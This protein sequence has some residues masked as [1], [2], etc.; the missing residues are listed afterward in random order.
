MTIKA[1]Q[2][3]EL[4]EATG[5]GLM[6]CKKALVENNGDLDKSIRWLRER[7]L[8][9]AAKKTSRVA[10]EGIVEIAIAD[11]KKTAVILE[12]NCETDFVA[13]NNDFISFAKEMASL[14]LTSGAK[15]IEALGLEKI[16]GQSVND[17]I[18]E[19]VAK[20][21][22]KISLRRMTRLQVSEGLVASYSH[23]GGRIGTL[24]AVQGAVSP[25]NEQLGLDIAMHVAAVAPKYLRSEDVDAKELEQE[26]EIARKKLL[27]Q[28]KPE[29]M[30]DKILMGQMKKFY[31]EICLL[32]QPYVREPKLRVQ[33]LIKQTGE[34]SQ[35][36]GFV[37]FQLGEGIE[38]KKEDFSAEV[39][40][41]LKG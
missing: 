28:G 32:D 29:A 34:Q 18:V 24:V 40:A 22:E 7:G 1:A 11:D 38:V 16:S 26:Q 35:I 5:M 36:E 31:S 12:I 8:S 9:R 20:I 41:Q 37:R 6:E 14:A 25:K 19:K 13:K 4:R 2:V 15:D 3:K 39:A 21:G 17:V 27:E 30:I 10:A 33:Q 23:M